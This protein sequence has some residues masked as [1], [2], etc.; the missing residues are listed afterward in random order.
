M[1]TPLLTTKLYIPPIRPDLVS[2][3]RL[4][5]QLNNGLRLSRRLTLI[6]ASPGFGKTTLLSEWA[7]QLG[8]GRMGWIG[9]DEGDNDPARFLAYVVSALKTVGLQL[10]DSLM[11]A[12]RSPQPPPFEAVLTALINE[13]AAASPVDLEERPI[14]LVLDDY[15]LVEAPAVHHAV[16]FL[17]D[18]LP[19][20]LHVAIAARADPPFP[21]G[22]LRGRGQM[23]ELR[24]ADL[25]FTFDEVASFLSTAMGMGVSED[26]VTALEARTEGWI[27]G[28]Q[29]A[30]LVLTPGRGWG[31]VSD[32][33]SPMTQHTPSAPSRPLLQTTEFL[34]RFT[35]SDRYIVDYLVEEVLAGHPEEVQSFLLQT[36]ILDRLTGPLC[37]VVRFGETAAVGISEAT[38]PSGHGDSAEMLDRLERAN[39]FVVPLDVGRRWFR[40]H[41]LFADAMRHRLERTQ[42][43]RVPELHRR[44]ARWYERQGF[45]TDAIGH[46]LSADAYAEAGRLMEDSALA[47]L[48]QGELMTL[49]SWIG[50][51][52]DD[53]VRARPHLCIYHAWALLLTGQADAVEARLQD[54]ESALGAQEATGSGEDAS[55]AAYLQDAQ[56]HIAAMRAYAATFGGDAGRATALAQEAL[57]RLSEENLFLRSFVAFLL[58]GACFMR[59]DVAGAGQAFREAAAMGREV[60]NVHLA[61]PA[62][63]ALA[64]LEEAQGKLHRAAATYRDAIELAAGSPVAA[65]AY[66]GTGEL[67]YEWNDLEAAAGFI[68]RGVELAQRWGNVDTLVNGLVS[69]ARLRTAQGNQE[70]AMAPMVQAEQSLRRQTALPGTDAT[71][72]AYRMRLYL[73]DGQVAAAMRFAAER[74]ISTDGELNLLREPEHIGLAR[75]LIER[76]AR[77]ASAYTARLLTFAQAGQR[78]GREIQILILGALAY[79][80]MGDQDQALE[81]L[82]RALS[83]AEPEDYLRTFLDEGPAMEQLLQQAASRG[84]APHYVNRLLKGFDLMTRAEERAANGAKSAPAAGSSALVEPLS[85]R[86]LEVLGLIADGLSNQRIADQLVIALGTVKA[87]TSSIYGKL[88][89]R[90]R[91]QAVARARELGLL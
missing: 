65:G 19:P 34:D 59:N 24:T 37:D 14:V 90:S 84:I 12:L 35:S 28:L 32:D 56:G 25:R 17:L 54:A 20:G 80:A 23:T 40:Y 78:P 29:L 4:I 58:G 88:G 53:L 7:A 49:L 83:L 82:E 67:L 72:A 26:D 55:T 36:S 6:S 2:R 21:L 91:T 63:R 89:V 81:A 51:L 79:R 74:G 3:P 66:I 27:T 48:A 60:G 15:H 22:R 73:W 47:F 11:G 45:T 50:R 61:V 76:N 38:A 39:M 71:L 9:L 1:Q 64:S 33:R 5:D 43:E 30:V 10:G 68:D 77:D 75:V 85:E 57:E 46:W 69:L 86:E 52:P 87:H 44:A 16:A 41:R 31:A 8:T 18:H 42:G 70:G 62:L 13:V